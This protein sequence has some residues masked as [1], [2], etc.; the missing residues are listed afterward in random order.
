MFNE[1]KEKYKKQYTD[2]TYE[3]LL[4]T[5]IASMFDWEFSEEIDTRFIESYLLI[6]GECAIWRLDGKLIVSVCNRAGAPNVNGLGKDL[7]CITGNGISKTFTDFENSRDVVYIRNNKFATPDLNIE[8]TAS[9]LSELYTSLRHNIIN[10]RYTPIVVAHDSRAKTAIEQVLKSNNSAE[11]QVVLSDNIF[12][13]EKETVLNVTDVNAQDKIQYINHAHDDVLRQF[14]S[15]YGL[16]TCGTSKMAQQSAD[17]IN[18][19]C[20]ARMVLPLDRLKERQESAQKII[21]FFGIDCSVEF[22]EAWR[23]EFERVTPH[24]ETPHA[25]TTQQTEAESEGEEDGTV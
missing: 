15:I 19:G 12:D 13:T 4:L 8:P 23:R 14:Y 5:D 17:E 6:F 20:N 21:D 3:D 7:I 1:L 18:A 24:A 10:A 2:R 11:I 16:D 25:E 22:S 9:I